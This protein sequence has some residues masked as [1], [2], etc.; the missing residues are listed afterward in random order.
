MTKHYYL[1]LFIFSGAVEG[2][3]K[4]N[5]FSVFRLDFRRPLKSDRCTGV[6]SIP[7]KRL[8]VQPTAFNSGIF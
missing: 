3:I 8:V 7:E 6:G 5:R 4:R 2:I 1:K